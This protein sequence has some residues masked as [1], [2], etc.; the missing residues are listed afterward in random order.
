MRGVSGAIHV[1]LC[2]GSCILS[3]YR[4]FFFIFLKLELNLNVLILAWKITHIYFTSFII[5]S[6]YYHSFGNLYFLQASFFLSD[7]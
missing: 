4:V 6:E 2:A 5:I 1:S 3:L 7:L